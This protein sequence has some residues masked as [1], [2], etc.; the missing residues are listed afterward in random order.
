VGSLLRSF[1]SS[2]RCSTE[3]V[4]SASLWHESLTPRQNQRKK[5][6]L[7]PEVVAGSRYSLVAL[8]RALLF[9]GSF[10]PPSLV[11]CELE[12]QRWS[13]KATST[14]YPPANFSVTD[15]LFC[16]VRRSLGA[17][18]SRHWSGDVCSSG[19]TS[20]QR[21]GITSIFADSSCLT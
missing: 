10:S 6:T 14:A 3:G 17:R 2:L 15:A 1:L 4:G 11:L 5:R 19:D 20:M 7:S 12:P 21:G 8:C 16:H 13:Y 18:V 9:L